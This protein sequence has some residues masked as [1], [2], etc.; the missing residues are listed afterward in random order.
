MAIEITMPQLGLT[1]TEGTVSQW[2]K[3]EGDA[4]KKGDEIVEIETD[5]ISNIVEAHEDGV[6]LKIVAQEGDSLP[7]KAVLGYI[8]QPGE[9]VGGGA[10]PATEAAAPAAPAAAPVQ[11]AA[12]AGGKTRIVV[13]G[14][15]PGGYVTAIKAAQLGADVAIVESGSVGG[16]CLNVGCIPTKALIHATSLYEAV[17]HQAA[18]VGV[19]VT[20]ASL[21]WGKAQQYKASIVKR[22]VGGVDGLL[23]AN[24]VKKYTGKGIVKDAHTVQVGSDT[25][26]ADYIILA[27]GSEPVH[28]RFPGAN[29]P[30][31]IDSTGAL[32]LEQVPKS[33]VIIG[34][35]VIGIEFASMF[36]AAGAQCT[37][38]EALPNIL[39]PID[40]EI[41]ALVQAD[42][43]KRGVKILT[44][45]KVE[46]IEGSGAELSVH[47]DYN[48]QKQ[49]VQGEKVIMAVGR[50]AL[51]GGI[52]LEEAGVALERGK[53]VTDDHFQTNIPSIFAI[54]DCNGKM[55]LAHAA[56]AQGVAAVEYILTGKC[57]YHS[58]TI[59]S[60][61]YLEPE[62]ASVGLKEEDLQARGIAYSCGKFALS[63]NGKSLI[64]NGGV[65][66][67]KIL[68]DTKYGQVLGVHMYGPR[69]TDLIAACALAIRLEST[70]DELTS[71]IWAH[72]TVGEAIGEAAEAVFGNAIHWPPKKK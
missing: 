55:M 68:A 30:G 2:L 66:L 39:P 21:D 56:S 25:I 72:P 47:M 20:G 28:L 16:T 49:A 14:A 37:I 19:S 41:V 44:N 12:P 1:M 61:I 43:E 18:Q 29:L 35:G 24:G 57:H 36:A 40:K 62:V 11:A 7:V 58:E 65:G 22:L 70:V 23:K 13:I 42:L 48:G 4:V 8:G 53:V 63:A 6:L 45:A 60:C 67:I 3:H 5:K 38:V 54:G 31:V 9:D 46:S 10:A 50:R 52:G 26:T 34:G 64:E 59:P 27:V 71:T 69:V 15:G 51:T 32:A 33:M 17:V